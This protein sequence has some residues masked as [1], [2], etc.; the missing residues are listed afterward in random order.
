M[1]PN[2]MK[3]LP[4]PSQTRDASFATLGGDN[5]MH[6]KHTTH[7]NDCQLLLLNSVQSSF[8]RTTVENQTNIP[9][10]N[11]RGPRRKQPALPPSKLSPMA[12]RAHMNILKKIGKQP[13]VEKQAEGSVFVPEISNVPSDYKPGKGAE[14]LMQYMLR[15]RNRPE[16]NNIQFWRNLV[17]EFFAPGATK[18]WCISLYKNVE[19]IDTIF[20]VEWQCNMC[21]QKPCYGFEMSEELLPRLHK[22]KYDTGL[23]DEHLQIDTPNE[24]KGAC[25]QIFLHY[26]KA[27][28]ESQYEQTRTVRNGQLRIVFSPDLKIRS[29]EFC[30]EDHDEYVHRNFIVPQVSQLGA[31]MENYRLS[32]Q[33]SSSATPEE[34][35]KHTDLLISS[36]NQMV[37]A[38][39]VPFISQIGVDKRYFRSL[40]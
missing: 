26:P 18:R 38:L 14:R 36:A 9:Q 5:M 23:V 31:A 30:A 13:L 4:L 20:K 6:N 11:Q 22:R 34:R 27:A 35:Q 17:A 19:Q 12:A 32:T 28:E 15:Q 25:G 1:D 21:N 39:G 33:E 8:D 24:Y 37:E 40:Q 10:H 2:G 3:P 29:W 16:D 7:R